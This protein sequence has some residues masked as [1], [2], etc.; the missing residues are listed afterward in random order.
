MI[1]LSAL[2]TALSS[3]GSGVSM[4]SGIYSTA[5]RISNLKPRGAFY[6]VRVH[7]KRSASQ[8]SRSNHRK[9]RAR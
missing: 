4:P 6:F 3:L 7:G 1:A 8:R 2:A 5:P 9:A